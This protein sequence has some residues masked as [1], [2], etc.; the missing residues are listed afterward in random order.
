MRFGVKNI[1]IVWFGILILFCGAYQPVIAGDIKSPMLQVTEI[2][3]RIY[4]HGFGVFP[5]PALSFGIGYHGDFGS[6]VYG[7]TG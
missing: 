6:S 1:R 7:G 5:K 2:K 3:D 4:D